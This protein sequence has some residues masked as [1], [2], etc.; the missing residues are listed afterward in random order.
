RFALRD[1]WVERDRDRERWLRLVLQ[2]RQL[3]H[4]LVEQLAHRLDV[5]L[6]VQLRAPELPRRREQLET[7]LHLAQLRSLQIARKARR[8]HLLTDDEVLRDR[9]VGLL[10]ARDVGELDQ[11]G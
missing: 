5:E 6:R 10:A 9:A 8:A 3:V 4:E 2:L 1:Q 7:A 11:P